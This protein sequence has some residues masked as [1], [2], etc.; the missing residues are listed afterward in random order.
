MNRPAFACRGSSVS[1][2][3]MTLPELMVAVGIGSL[4]L[5]GVA[6]LFIYGLT[7]F[8]SLGNYTGLT[9]QSRL[10]VDLMS[11]DI[12]SATGLVSSQPNLPVKQL[13][14]TNAF[15][16]TTVTYAWDSTTQV[17]T[18]TRS[19]QPVHTNLT[20]CTGWTFSFYQRTPNKSWT[21]YPT[22]DP[23]LCKLINMSWKCSRSILGNA[24]NTENLVTAQVVLRNKP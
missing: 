3:G 9:S 23:A 6:T 15:D 8:A 2:R 19:G 11:R 7:S 5:A 18:S 22:S 12:R 21:F 10:A 16:G 1:Q 14:L 4:V 13:T 17:L 24:I 20:G